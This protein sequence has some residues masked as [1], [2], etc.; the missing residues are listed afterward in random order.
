MTNH[1]QKTNKNAKPSYHGPSI[2]LR[3][4]DN[5]LRVKCAGL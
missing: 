2:T 1:A 4:H 5:A 3:I